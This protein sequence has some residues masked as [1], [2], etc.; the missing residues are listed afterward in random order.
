MLYAIFWIMVGVFIG[1]NLE[2]PHWARELQAKVVGLVKAVI[3]GNG[4]ASGGPRGPR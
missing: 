4:G 3:G 2:Q 1:W